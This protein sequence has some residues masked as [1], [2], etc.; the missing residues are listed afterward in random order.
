MSSATSDLFSDQRVHRICKSL[1]EMGFDVKAVG[2]KKPDSPDL[3][4]REYEADR[5]KMTFHKGPLFYAEY[6]IRFSFISVNPE[7]IF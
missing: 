3:D 4:K 1:R 6:N 5:L 2:R 7:P